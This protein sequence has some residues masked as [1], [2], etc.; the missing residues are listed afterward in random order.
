MLRA[1]IVGLAVSLAVVA[2]VA[3]SQNDTQSQSDVASKILAL[4]WIKA[5]ATAPIAGGCSYQTHK[6]S[7]GAWVRSDTSRFVELNGNPP[8]ERQLCCISAQLPMVLGFRL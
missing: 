2:T 7:D 5:P 4:N 1:L 6:W 3:Q 8:V